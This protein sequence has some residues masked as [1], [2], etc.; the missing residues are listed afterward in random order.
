MSRAATL[1]QMQGIDLEVDSHRARLAAIEQ[2]LGDEPAVREAQQALVE[3]QTQLHT[4]RVEVQNLEYENQTLA[5]KLA[6]AN[7]RM[8]GGSVT[9]PKELRDLQMEI[10]SLQRRRTALEERQFEALMAA[11]AAET[12]HAAV[13]EQLQA[14]SAAAAATHGSLLDERGRL[15]AALEH[16]ATAREAVGAQVLAADRELYD[17]LRPAKKGRAVSKLEDGGCS[18]CG[19]APSSSRIQSARQGN[20][21]ILCGNCGRILCAD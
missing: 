10:D 14:A 17:R 1:L 21:L 8:Y 9:N 13:Q 16:L 12:R 4:A 3:A 20:E 7:R 18:T 15:S 11:E 2:Q 6:E 5:E 19:V